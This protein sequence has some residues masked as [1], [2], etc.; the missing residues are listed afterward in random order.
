MSETNFQSVWRKVS[1]PNGAAENIFAIA[2]ILGTA[3]V[4]A[5][6][7]ALIY[8]A[9][10]PVFQQDSFTAAALTQAFRRDPAGFAS[11]YNGK[12]ITAYGLLASPPAEQLKDGKHFVGCSLDA[13]DGTHGNDTVLVIFEDRGQGFSPQFVSW[14]QAA[15]T[16]T[17]VSVTGTFGVRTDVAAP[18]IRDAKMN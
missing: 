11:R 3:S 14:F 17:Y 13:S 5:G 10:L 4:V 7:V 15:R 16:G 8:F 6:V 2:V 18:L 12:T 9:A 1:R